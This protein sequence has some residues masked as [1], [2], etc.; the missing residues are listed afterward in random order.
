MDVNEKIRRLMEERGWSAYRLAKQCGL[1]VATIG[2]L[3]RRNTTPSIA[4]LEA[5]CSGLNITLAQFFAE[6]DL[7]EM[8]PEAKDSVVKGFDVLEHKSV[9]VSAV[10]DPEAAEPFA[11]DERVKGFDAGVVVGISLL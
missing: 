10:F 6:G 9:S 7:V 1:S 2:N 5:I 3:F 8:T 11:L 4:T